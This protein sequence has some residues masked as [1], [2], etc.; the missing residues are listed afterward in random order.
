MIRARCRR[1]AFL[2]GITISVLGAALPHSRALAVALRILPFA[3]DS[4][5]SPPTNSSLTP[6]NHSGPRP[7]RDGSRSHAPWTDVT[8][9]TDWGWVG[10]QMI[11]DGENGAILA[12]YGAPSD[13]PANVD[14]YAQ[15]IGPSA[16]KR[17]ATNGVFVCSAPGAQYNEV[18]VTDGDGGAILAW[19]DRRDDVRSSIYG[20][21]VTRDGAVAWAPDG[22]RLTETEAVTPVMAPDGQGGAVIVWE[23]WVDGFF[24]IR[25]QRVS[26]TG[27]LL[28]GPSGVGVCTAPGRHVG[29]K[30]C[31][32][33]AGGAFVAWTDGRGAIP[34]VFAQHLSSSGVPLW[35]DQ[36]V[37][38]CP[39]TSAQ[40]AAALVP[41]PGGTATIVWADSRN[42]PVDYFGLFAQ[43][44]SSSG[45]DIWK[46]EG[47]ALS[48]E[49]VSEHISLTA[50]MDGDDLV[51]LW[52]ERRGSQFDTYAQRLDRLGNRLMG[53]AGTVIADGPGDQIY[54]RATFDR[55]HGMIVAWTDV[56]SSPFRTSFVAQ[57]TDAL[58]NRVWGPDGIVLA[59]IG[60][61]A[62]QALTSDGR[63]GAFAAWTANVG[64]NRIHVTHITDARSNATT[65]GG[66]LAS[67]TRVASIRANE[68]LECRAELDPSNPVSPHG[69]A[70]L[71][72]SVPR[73]ESVELA[74]FDLGGRHI[75]TILSGTQPAGRHVVRWNAASLRPGVYSVRLRVADET[76]SRKIIVVK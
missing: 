37:A 44:L 9:S 66:I 61:D 70:S 43:R 59:S 64:D 73:Q 32:D 14:I 42:R 48:E 36:G 34:S 40:R 5:V 54:P 13:D 72:Y 56:R 29:P 71:S 52:H 57:H 17:W 62:E 15:R 60:S 21:R 7:I 68:R 18:L 8:V 27:R 74:V 35:A 46:K 65:A 2:L 4:L 10:S 23:D 31:S 3:Q 50:Q 41:D 33:G 38:V 11:P 22:I 45:K 76:Q 39:E 67:R 53:P 28:W 75:L 24:K 69:A 20:Q 12:W 26:H 19:T 6:E 49:T 58:G 55:D 16:E 51:S 30:I 63:G 47:V 1:G 25:A